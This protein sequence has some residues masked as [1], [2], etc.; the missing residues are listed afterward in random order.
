MFN[1]LK[2]ALF[3]DDNPRLHRIPFLLLWVTSYGLAWLSIYF[4]ETVLWYNPG[5]WDFL[6]SLK[7]TT[8]SWAEETLL[9]LAFG[10][11]LATIQAW[12]LRRRYGFVPKFWRIATFL[13]VILAAQ[14][15][16]RVGVNVGGTQIS[17]EDYLVWFI[18]PTIFQASVLY[19][20]NRKAW[21]LI[22]IGV[23]AAAVS[24]ISLETLQGFRN[25]KIA[26]ILSTA[27]QSLG[28]GGLILH[29]MA[30]PRQ[31]SVPKREKRK[32]Q[33][34]TQWLVGRKA[35]ILWSISIPYVIFMVPLILVTF[36]DRY[37]PRR[38]IISYD[39][40]AIILAGFLG[41][42]VGIMQQWLIYQYSHVRIRYWALV[43]MIGAAIGV[44]L[45]WL[46]DLGG[47]RDF[48][49]YFHALQICVFFAAPVLFQAILMQRTL[50]GGLLWLTG[51][52]VA[53]FG[54]SLI[55]IFNDT[56]FGIWAWC[57]SLLWLSLTT[58]IAFF[59]IIEVSSYKVI[60]PA[61]DLLA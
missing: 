28:T 3:E 17:I 9:G 19:T 8:S 20:I 59:R 21:W 15:Y 41:F 39:V 48:G 34:D 18:L 32:E 33:T 5:L 6:W 13:G 50:G 4:Y 56:Y 22:G 16:P 26:L 53:G 36:F 57:L 12:L 27:I 7:Y 51:Y 37:I 23:A 1:Y 25:I 42:I 55:M 38:P 14:Y 45:L 52:I 2:S 31:G 61:S 40:D 29:L 44:I 43:T 60:H 10:I 35:F 58:S 24:I 54:T 49:V 30:Y 46:I 11:I 47:Y